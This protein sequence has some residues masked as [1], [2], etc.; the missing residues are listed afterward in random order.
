M[1]SL[2][3]HFGSTGQTCVNPDGLVRMGRRLLETRDRVV[4]SRD[5][6]PNSDTL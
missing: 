1:A 5:M 2:N 4:P 3:R 6:G